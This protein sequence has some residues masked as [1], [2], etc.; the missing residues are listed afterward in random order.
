MS[1]DRAS[2]NGLDPMI[3]PFV[4][5]WGS[6]VQQASDNTRQL[7]ETIEPGLP[8]L[9]VPFDPVGHFFQRRGLET[10]GAPLRVAS[11]RDQAGP[12]E[13][14][15]VFRDRRHAHVERL[16]ELGD[17]RLAGGETGENGAAGRVGQG[18]ERGVEGAVRTLSVYNH[19]V[20]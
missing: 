5:F 8:H 20:N 2:S 16:R 18:A 12:L 9:A 13:H 1:A 10:A 17:R 11:A 4:D 14:L 7:V 6:L 19:S 15:Q 3:Q